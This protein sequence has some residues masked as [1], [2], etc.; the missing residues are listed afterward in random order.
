MR[1]NNNNSTDSDMPEDLGEEEMAEGVDIMACHTFT[2]KPRAMS[3]LSY[4]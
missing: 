4:Q 1:D 2:K 3:E